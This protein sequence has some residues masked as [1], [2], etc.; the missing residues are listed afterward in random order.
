MNQPN[1]KASLL[2]ISG[3]D[4]LRGSDSQPVNRTRAGA[5]RIARKMASHGFVP[6][7]VP[8]PI[9]DLLDG[10]APSYWRLSF[11]KQPSAAA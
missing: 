3:L 11:G 7:V 2:I 10:R 6:H 5:M 1:H 4:Y 8:G 9:E